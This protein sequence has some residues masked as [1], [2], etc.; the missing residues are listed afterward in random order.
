MKDPKSYV[1]KLSETVGNYDNDAKQL[2]DA[3]HDS[4]IH[5]QNLVFSFDSEEVKEAQ[6]QLGISLKEQNTSLLELTL[7][8]LK[9][10]KPIFSL[11]KHLG[12][13]FPTEITSEYSVYRYLMHDTLYDTLKNILQVLCQALQTQSKETETKTPSILDLMSE[14]DIE[15]VKVCI[16]NLSAHKF[17]LPA[18]DERISF[19]TN[20]SA[21]LI[22]YTNCDANSNANV[23]ANSD[24]VDYD[25][26]MKF[27]GWN[28]DKNSESNKLGGDSDNNNEQLTAIVKNMDIDQ[29]TI[30]V[31]DAKEQVLDNN[32]EEAMEIEY[33]VDTDEQL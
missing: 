4:L 22:F 33:D 21:L 7:L 31:I 27:H 30:E 15:A 12:C 3:I 9:N 8:L 29:K 13:M 14:K 16:D 6:Q 26:L 5:Q 11:S 19:L 32:N 28:N 2:E 20:T 23:N 17:N 25:L 1:S 24:L 10:R 18:V